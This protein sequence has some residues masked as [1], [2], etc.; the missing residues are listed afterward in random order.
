[1]YIGYKQ[2]LEH[3]NSLPKMDTTKIYEISESLCKSRYYPD[4]PKSTDIKNFLKRPERYFFYFLTKDK[5]V[6]TYIKHCCYYDKI[7]DAKN[8]INCLKDKYYKDSF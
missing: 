2:K 5:N 6:K 7:E 3:F 1:M 4:K 8:A